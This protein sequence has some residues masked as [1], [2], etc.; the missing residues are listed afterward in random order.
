MLAPTMNYMFELS[1]EHPDLPVWEA[2]ALLRCSGKTELIDRDY[3]LAIFSSGAMPSEFKDRIALSHFLNEHLASVKP[4][5][6]VSFFEELDFNGVKSAAV[7]VKVA[8]LEKGEY[9]PVALAKEIG[10]AISGRTKIELTEP[11]EKFRVMVGDKAHIGREIAEI[12]RTQYEK[13][14][15]RFLPFNSPISI[16]PRLAR[17]LINM[18][19]NSRKCKILD[20]FCGTGT[21]LIESA[22]MG[23]DA[24]GSDLSEKM[25]EGSRANLKQLGLEA[26]LKKSDVA[27]ISK[28]NKKF[29]CI[30]TDPPYGRSSSTNK[31]AIEDLYSRALRSFAGNLTENGR[32]GIIVPDQKTLDFEDDFRIIRKASVRAHRSLVRNFIVL[33]K[34]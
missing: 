21:L 26:D 6:L 32:V 2:E 25:I 20:P 12:D 4:D 34:V 11:M 8:E 13:R 9:D 22:L 15:N 31:E 3:N 1:G 10:A 18:T 14:K 30:V 16:H 23:M 27:E 33:E 5:R 17:A 28:F 29:D 7:K 19:A 24:H